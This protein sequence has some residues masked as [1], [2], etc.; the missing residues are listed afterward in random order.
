M[1][2]ELTIDNKE[3]GT[4]IAGDVYTEDASFDHAFGTED[5]VEYLVKNVEVIIYLFDEEIDITKEI[6]E[7]HFKELLI[8]EYK[9]QIEGYDG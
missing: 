8:K 5:R 2:V 1:R 4:F 3:I 6:K 7:D 9:K